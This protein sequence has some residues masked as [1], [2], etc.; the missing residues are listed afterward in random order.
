MLSLV[1]G[2]GGEGSCIAMVGTTLRV[3]KG[4]C[5]ERGVRKAECGENTNSFS[6]V[7]YV[8]HHQTKQVT[9]RDIHETKRKHKQHLTPPNNLSPISIPQA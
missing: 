7:K 3:M 5:G 4:V 8:Q 6:L 9:R 2:E 1:E